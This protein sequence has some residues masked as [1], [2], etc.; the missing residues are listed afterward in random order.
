MITA[1]AIIYIILIQILSTAQYKDFSRF[2]HIN[3]YYCDVRVRRKGLQSHISQITVD[4][5]LNDNGTHYSSA[6]TRDLWSRVQVI[7]ITGA[8]ILGFVRNNKNLMVSQSC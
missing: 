3:I 6:A 7:P 2:P 1:V 4:I 5:E 8:T